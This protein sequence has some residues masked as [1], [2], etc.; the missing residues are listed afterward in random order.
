MKIVI[1]KCFGGFGLS[2]E[3][4]RALAARQGVTLFEHADNFG[5]VDFYTVPWEE[6]KAACK[7]KGPLGPDR[8]AST[9]GMFYYL[10]GDIARDDA[11]LVAVV[12][13]LGAA[14]WDRFAELAVVEIPDGTSW[15]LEDY[16]GVETIYETHESWS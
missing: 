13:E 5:G 16:D 8:F 12:E 9:K 6:Y 1:N 10:D 2:D 3:A 14:S 11:D 15:E 4:T 7:I